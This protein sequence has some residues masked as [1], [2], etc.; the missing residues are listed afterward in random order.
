MKARELRQ[1]SDEE[2]QAKYEELR[3][4]LFKLRIQKTIG[5]LDNPAKIKMVKRDIARIL[6][7]LREREVKNE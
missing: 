1:L 3:E 2:L 5:Q 4:Q 7:I 6:T